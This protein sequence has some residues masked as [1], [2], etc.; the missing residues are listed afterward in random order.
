MGC[1]PPPPADHEVTRF[2]RI[3]IDPPA[4]APEYWPWTREAMKQWR[5]RDCPDWVTDGIESC[6]TCRPA[7]VDV[8]S[9]TERFFVGFDKDCQRVEVL[10]GQHVDLEMVS[11]SL[12]A[13]SDK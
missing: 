5:R 8:E 10:A 6:F 2:T 4:D 13:R 1:G 9:S 3:R 7:S 12:R 11:K